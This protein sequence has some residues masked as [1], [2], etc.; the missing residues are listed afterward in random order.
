MRTLFLFIAKIVFGLVLSLGLI[1][2]IGIFYLQ[3]DLPQV[4]VLKDVYFQIPLKI[5]SADNKLI[6]EFGEKKRSPLSYQNIPQPLIHAFLAAEDSRF[7]NHHGIDFKSILRAVKQMVLDEDVQT[8]ASTITMQVARNFFLTSDR[9][10]KRKAKEILLALGIEE[11]ISK[12]E[13]FALYVNKIFLGFSSYGIEAASK[14]YYNKSVNQLTL[15][16]MAMLASLPKGPSKLNPIVNPERAKQRRNWVL[17]RML[18]HGFITEKDYQKAVDE[19]ITATQTHLAN[20]GTEAEYVA[21]MVRIRLLTDNKYLDTI[22]AEALYTRGYKVYTTINSRMQEAAN[23]SLRNGLIRYDKQHGYRGTEAHYPELVTALKTQDQSKV[24][25]LYAKKLEQIDDY[26][27]SLIPALVLEV[28]Q[29]KIKILTKDKLIAYIALPEIHWAARYINADRKGAKP[30]SPADVFQ[31]GD[32]LRTAYNPQ[33]KVWELR[34]KPNIEGALVSIN[35]KTGAIQSLIG[36]YHYNISKFN[37][38]TQAERQ[39]GSSFKPFVYATAIAS[40]LSAATLIND[41]PIIDKEWLPNNADGKFQ[42]LMTLR[43]GLYFSKNLV[44]IRLVDYLKVKNVIEYAQ[45]FGFTKESL[46]YDLS[47]ALGTAN[48][49]PILLAKAYST[50]ANRG[51]SIDPYIIERVEDNKGQIVYQADPAKICSGISCRE[52]DNPAKQ[53]IDPQVAYIMDDMLR[54]VIQKG[55][56]RRALKLGRN[57]IAGKTG[58]T[59][60][61][62]DTWFAG[63]NPNLVTIVWVG[64]DQPDTLGKR[65]YGNTT[66]LPIW[67][68][69]MQVALKNEPLTYMKRPPG[70]VG[71]TIDPVNGLLIDEDDPHAIEEIFRINN[72]PKAYSVNPVMMKDPYD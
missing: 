30:E 9:T 45:Y 1:V 41:A 50:F 49:T 12:E 20:K 63:Y 67:I 7:F 62:K 71:V 54:D 2:S 6:A 27:R 25:D 13:I 53:V 59:N 55:T 17:Q 3:K 51:Y 57:D 40:G 37:R 56:G 21:E 48:G 19:P 39:M 34:Q 4:D 64:F 31:P 35:P 28:D 14:T 43:K 66:A 69:Y 58:T 10:L 22:N 47:L 8:G 38:V 23:T 18:F 5:Y 65:E 33:K 52:T 32:L 68:D 44:A 16:Q 46:P 24:I 36:G 42:G 26:S 72:V 11:K 60:E 15:A 70:I 61:N 29:E